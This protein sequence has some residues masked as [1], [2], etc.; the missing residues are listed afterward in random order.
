VHRGAAVRVRVKGLEAGEQVT[1]RAGGKVL[2]ETANARGK[3]KVKVRAAKVGK[4]KVKVVGV[5]ANRKGRTT[6]RVLR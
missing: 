3:V 4:L 1:I 6:V 2:E 5:F